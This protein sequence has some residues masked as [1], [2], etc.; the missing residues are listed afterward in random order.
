MATLPK[1]YLNY[2]QIV[3]DFRETEIIC[4]AGKTVNKLS[5]N[6]NITSKHSSVGFITDFA[7]K[8]YIL[9]HEGCVHITGYTS[10]YFL[11]GGVES[12]IS[13]WREFDFDLY[14]KKIFLDNLKAIREHSQDIIPD[15]V[16]S[17][18]YH[19]KKRDGNEAKLLQRVSFIMNAACTIPI[20]AVG[21]VTDISHFKN[22]ENLLH[23]IEAVHNNGSMRLLH[24]KVY[25]KDESLTQLGKKEIE[26][27]KW[28]SAGFSSKQIAA[29]MHISIYT[30]NNHR[31]NMLYKSNCLNVFQLVAFA[32][33][34]GLI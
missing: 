29:K 17:H 5:K 23:T 13:K 31:K 6:F 22:N 20:G 34:N 24:K 19:I 9:V 25:F 1:S 15:I 21:T 18:T 33:K 4:K 12:Y 11:K 14:N 28:V 16:F 3:P 8:K 7:Q 32:V 26:V 10:R 27:L 2:L 30:V